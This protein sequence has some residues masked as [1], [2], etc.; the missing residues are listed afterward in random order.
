MCADVRD[1]HFSQAGWLV[2]FRDPLVSTSPETIEALDFTCWV[3]GLP[4]VLMLAWQALCKR[5]SY[6]DLCLRFKYYEV[7]NFDKFSTEHSKYPRR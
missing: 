4:Q 1:Q 3:W 6:T 2:S 7:V 5:T